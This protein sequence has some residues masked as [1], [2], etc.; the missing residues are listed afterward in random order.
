[1]KLSQLEGGAQI[2]GAKERNG[3]S[4]D[5]HAATFQEFPRVPLAQRNAEQPNKQT[6]ELPSAITTPKP[7]AFKLIF[8][9]A[10]KETNNNIIIKNKSFILVWIA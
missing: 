10:K 9:P 2:K 5:A 3:P 4:E 1:M 6:E 7:A 8:Q